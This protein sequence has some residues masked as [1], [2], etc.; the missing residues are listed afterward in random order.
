[1]MKHEFDA[2]VGITIDPECYKKIEVC[3]MTFDNLFPDKQSVADYYKKHD[4]NGFEKLYKDALK[5]RETED[6]LKGSKF[7]VELLKRQLEELSEPKM[8]M[9]IQ[10]S[11]SKSRT[12]GLKHLSVNSDLDTQECSVGVNE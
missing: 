11:L 4:M 10:F 9:M 3:Y 7:D 12:P 1:M 8:D 6:A 2:L 5:F